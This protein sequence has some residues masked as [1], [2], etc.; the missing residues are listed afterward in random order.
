MTPE[1]LDAFRRADPG[2]YYPD[3]GEPA[4][5]PCGAVLRVVGVVLAVAFLIWRMA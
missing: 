5:V 2:Y 4:A 1:D 3:E